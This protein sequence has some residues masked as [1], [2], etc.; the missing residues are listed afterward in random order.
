MPEFLTP[1]EILRLHRDQI[2]RYGGDPGIRDM[3][4]FL[5]AIAAPQ[6]G[7]A[8]KF[9]HGDIIEMAAAYLYHIVKNHPFVDG[10]RKSVV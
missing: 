5:S 7:M 10:D 8:G 3:K 2:E 6:A 4:L 9:L 1:E